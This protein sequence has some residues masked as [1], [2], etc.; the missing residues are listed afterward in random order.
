MSSAVWAYSRVSGDERADGGL[1][2]ECGENLC[3]PS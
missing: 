1:S 2:V 3:V